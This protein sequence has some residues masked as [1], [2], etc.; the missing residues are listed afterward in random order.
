MLVLTTQ[1][2]NVIHPIAYGDWEEYELVINETIIGTLTVINSKSSVYI[3]LL[4]IFD[5]HKGK[6]Y[7]T[8]IVSELFDFFKDANAL[9]GIAWE[10]V[11]NGFWAKQPGFCYTGECSDEFEDYFSFEF[12]RH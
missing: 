3:D 1:S 10:D 9:W 12:L 8:Q 2:E 7:G 5:E 6:G 4:S 11:L